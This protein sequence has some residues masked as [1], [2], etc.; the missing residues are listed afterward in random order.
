MAEAR[1]RISIHDPF[2]DEYD[3]TA[4]KINALWRSYNKYIWYESKSFWRQGNISHAPQQIP[5]LS[6][7]FEEDSLDDLSELLKF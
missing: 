3:K 4:N 6:D 1:N 7:S 2:F 5:L